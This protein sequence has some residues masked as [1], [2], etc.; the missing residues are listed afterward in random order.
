MTTDQGTK[1]S[2]AWQTINYNQIASRPNTLNGYGINAF[3]SSTQGNYAN[4]NNYLTHENLSRNKFRAFFNTDGSNTNNAQQFANYQIN[5][6][7]YVT[8][9][10]GGYHYMYINVLNANDA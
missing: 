8:W 2:N 10:Q 5:G 6:G 3:M 9:T 1:A 7:N 4:A